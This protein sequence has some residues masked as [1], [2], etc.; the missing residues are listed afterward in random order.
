[1]CGIPYHAAE[2]YIARLIAKGYKVAICEQME[3][4]ATGQGPGEAGHHPGGDPRHRHRRRLPGGE[5]AATICCGIYLDRHAARAVGFCDISTGK[6]HVTA[7]SGPDRAEHLHQRAGPVLPGGGGAERRRPTASR[8]LTG[9]PDRT[10]STAA[11]KT[12]ASGRFRLPEA[13]KNIRAAVRRGGLAGAC[14]GNPAAAMA[15]G[16]AAE[17]SLRD[18]ENRPVATSDDLDY[19]QQGQFMELDLTARRNLEL[20][21]TLRGKEKKGSLL[22]VLDKTKTPMG[23]RM[24]RSWLERPLL[25]V[26]A[27]DPPQRRRGRAGGRHHRPGR[28]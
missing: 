22:W 14:P 7:F 16:G 15:L 25:S 3:D 27:I 2:A 9:R 6:T 11:V 23:G 12:A 17:L 28:S 5:D 8:P 20:T 24:L 1:M 13:E 19:Y 18:P 4:P 26:T 10:S 21:E